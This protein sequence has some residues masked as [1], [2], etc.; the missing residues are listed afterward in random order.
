MSASSP[1]A[2][3]LLAVGITAAVAAISITPASAQ[4]P[5]APATTAAAAPR[6]PWGE[7]DLQ[8]IWT[9][10]S[11]TPLQRL[12]KYA[13]QEFFTEAQRAEL[14]RARAA[15]LARDGRAAR[16]TETD[17]TGAYNSVSSP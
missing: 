16:G 13:A 17:V 5:A 1:I 4:A 12:A 3:G 2:P 11:D 8:G 15:L 7:P 10:E 9:D 14:D 6:T